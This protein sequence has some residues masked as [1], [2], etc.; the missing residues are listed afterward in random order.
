MDF[1]G[2]V[3]IGAGIILGGWLALVIIG[4]IMGLVER[5]RE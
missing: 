3:A 1:F 5:A 4:M 2:A